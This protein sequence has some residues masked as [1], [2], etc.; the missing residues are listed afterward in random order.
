MRRSVRSFCRVGVVGVVALALI[1]GSMTPAAAEEKPAVDAP[2]TLDE[3]LEV[4]AEESAPVVEEAPSVPAPDTPMVVE[5]A[6][7]PADVDDE[8]TD[9][10]VA[11]VSDLVEAPDDVPDGAEIVDR[12]EFETTYDVGDGVMYTQLSSEPSNVR[13]DGSWKPIVTD[14]VGVGFWSFLGVGG[15]E[16]LQHPLQPRFAETAS[17]EGLLRLSRG[18]YEL[19][20]TLADAADSK[21]T[22][23]PNPFGGNKSRLMYPDVFKGTHLRFEVEPGGVKEVFELAQAPGPNGRTSWEWLVDTDG[24]DMVETDSGTLELRDGDD[25]RFVLPAPHMW[26]SAGR[27]GDQANAER[28]VDAHVKRVGDLWRLKLTANRLWL[29][30]A[31]RVYPVFVDPEAWYG[32]SVTHAYKTNGQ[33]NQNYGIQVGNTNTNG[34]WRSVAYYDYT[35]LFG[36]QV[37]DANMYYGGLSSDSTQTARTNYLHHATCLCYNGAGKVLGPFV[38]GGGAGDSATDDARL[39][40]QVATWVRGSSG[41]NYFMFVGEEAPGFTYK[42]LTASQLGVL[43]KVFPTPGSPSTPLNGSIVGQTPLLTSA[44]AT[45][46]AGYQVSWRFKVGT[47]SNVDASQVWTSGWVGSAGIGKSQARVGAGALLPGT[48]YYWKVEIHDTA[49]GVLGTSTLRSSAVANFTTNKP[50]MPA[51]EIA[52]PADGAKVASTTPT[53]TVPPV[54]DR[55]GDPVQYKFQV[56]TGSDGISGAIASSGWIPTPEWTPPEGTLQDGGAYTWTV[57][58][59]DPIEE[60]GPKWVNRLSVD[61]R[62]GASGPSPTDQGGPVSVNLG[63]G[64]ANLT[65]ASPTV[66]TVGGPMGLS[67]NYSAHRDNR[68]LTGTYYDATPPAG[69]TINPDI[70]T[71]KPGMV[72]TDPQISFNWAAEEP[73]GPGIPANNFIVNW[74]GFLK[75]SAAGTY[76]FGVIRDN[77]VRLTLDGAVVIDKYTKTHSAGLVEWAAQPTSMTAGAVPI[78]LQYFDDGGPAIAQ[79]WVRDAAGKEFIVPADWYTRTLP[80]LP[81]G[82]DASAPIAGADGGYVS[83]RASETALAFTDRTGGTVTYKKTSR[84]G[85]AAPTG[86]YGTA[87]VDTAGNVTLTGADGVVSVFDAAG[88][89]A[90]TSSPL[91]GKKPASPKIGYGG[92]G[93]ILTISDRLSANG[94]GFDRQ[95]RFAYGKDLASE[96]GL[97]GGNGPACPVPADTAYV[98]PDPEQLCR[99]IY[100]GSAGEEDTTRLYYAERE[101]TV[102]GGATTTEKYVAAIIDP[103]AETVQFEFDEHRRLVGIRSPLEVDWRLH[104]NAPPSDANRTTIAYDAAG[105]VASVALAAPDGV[106]MTDR[107]VKRYTYETGR[108]FVDI[109][110]FDVPNDGVSNGHARTVTFN[111]ALQQT[112]AISAAGLTGFTE[113]NNKD[114]VLSTTDT[115]GRKSTTV[116][117]GRDRPA[118]AYGPAPADCFDANRVPLA[119]CPITPAKSTTAYDEGLLGLSAAYFDN[120]TLTGVPDV[121][122]LGIGHAAGN[123]VREW[124]TAAPIAG[125]PADKWA[126]RLTGVLTF[127]TPGTYKL[128]TYNDDATQLWVDDVLK[129]DNW[130]VDVLRYSSEA[131]ITTTVANERHRVR[132]QYMD[133]SGGAHLQLM[134]TKPGTSTTVAIPGAQLTPDYGLSTSSTTADGVPAGSVLPA[135]SVIPLT[136]ATKYGW[137]PWLGLPVDEVVDP[138]GLNLTTRTGYEAE[139]AGYLRRTSRMLPA[140]VAAGATVAQAGTAY[141]YYGDKETLAQAWGATGPICGVPAGTPQYGAL[142][143]ANAATAADDARVVTEQVHDFWGRAVG[144]KRT[145]DTAWTCTSM[146]ARGRST[147]VAY[148]ADGDASERIATFTHAVDGDPLTNRAEDPAGAIT[149]VTDLLGRVVSYTDVWGV[150]STAEYNLLG[151]VSASTATPP[152]GNAST[153]TLTYNLDGQVE[154]IAVDDA[155]IADPIYDRGQLTGVTYANGTS[156][157]EVQRSM[158]GAL[159]DMSWL[160]PNGQAAVTDA[161]IRAQSGRIVANTLTDGASVYASRYGFDAAG[162]LVSAVIPGHTLS[163]A[164]GGGCGVNTGA[165]LNGNRTSFTDVPDGGTPVTTSYC[166]DHTDR[167]TST[168]V[169]GTPA[170]P[171]LSPVG[172]AIPAAQLAYDAHGNTTKLADQSLG[173]DV[174]DQHVETTLSDGTVV[175][176]RRDV[177]GRIIQRTETPA[178]QNPEVTVVRY[179]FTG[180]G[181]SP[182][183]ILD[184]QSSVLQRVLG[185]PGGVTVTTSSASESWSYPN[186]HGDVTVT[187]DATGT[188]SAGVFRYDP[189]GQPVDPGTG[190][191]GTPAADDAGPDTLTGN[192]DWG[193]LGTHRK[194]TEHAGSIHT[195]EMGARQYVPALGRF[196]EVDPIEG[197]V[198]SN[199]DYPADPINKLDLSGERAC[200]SA[201][202]CAQGKTTKQG[203]F[204]SNPYWGKIIPLLGPGNK[205]GPG[206]SAPS[207]SLHRLPGLS[208]NRAQYY[209]GADPGPAWAAAGNVILG[210]PDFFAN[211]IVASVS[212][213]KNSGAVSGVFRDLDPEDAAGL[214]Y[215][216][217]LFVEAELA[218][219]QDGGWFVRKWRYEQ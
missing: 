155:V 202:E 132:L 12:S 33:Y 76:T 44:G 29:N 214:T 204:V 77:G 209:G 94:S 111:T 9:G 133:Y 81:A 199:Y 61:L 188:R 52:V 58:T 128:K 93:R 161:V 13:I 49:D 217:L 138:A 142:K 98:A 169:T 82:W 127:P 174:S 43:W 189:F 21:L 196:L 63:N 208:V 102:E 177:T 6:A 119:S 158:A 68:G 166:Y 120:E 74:A 176:Y 116:Y 80:V 19:S 207:I 88:K 27:D 179:G 110:G 126:V 106:T 215:D 150:V 218:Y 38:T 75:P 185:L 20:F 113:W 171:G 99:I 213:G 156:L 15:A 131:T 147:A 187:A 39:S 115:W 92:D 18:G 117:D 118:A 152:G 211:L 108:T 167:L 34:M 54:V 62:L 200:T 134:W 59:K 55:L 121:Y 205:P 101:V 84:G 70:G 96:F 146:D 159:V 83:V 154:T 41:G 105:R 78:Q 193:W 36:K 136:T 165:G 57:F 51:Q 97:P 67:F 144:S 212:Q 24:L 175:A 16:A 114:Q 181:D 90:E 85:F 173:Y 3:V 180:G 8:R 47:T 172:S 73:P 143:S 216:S 206:I 198:T 22:R 35:G 170:G 53:F 28:S 79:L 14:V 149:T 89:L 95:V 137:S 195:I 5:T 162:R 45:S 191:I 1:A 129:I 178:G 17:D 11:E 72:R 151:Q 140:G 139:D 10:G 65:F 201:L 48:K 160:F 125:I 186:I 184:A 203:R 135:D 40:Q 30:D 168:T 153:T 107:P 112:S 56:A 26:D 141:T 194:L 123:V 130:R 23:D 192:A 197:G 60:Y 182:A 4:P 46:A 109:E 164:F 145:G 104:T 7:P 64:N 163:Y 103:G 87:S 183:L 25:V 219:W 190:Q 124:S 157:A 91:E 69:Q 122:A 32:P 148:P 86:H 210:S 66:S 37:L 50:G 71:R 31:D 42:H 2:L 100:P